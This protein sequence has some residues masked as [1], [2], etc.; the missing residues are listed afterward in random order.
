MVVAVLVI[1]PYGWGPVYNFP[2]PAPFTGAQIWNPYASL[3]GTWQRANLH[4]HGQAWGGLTNGEQPDA[5]VATRYRDLGYTVAG[6]SNYMSIAAEHGIDTIPLYEHGFNLGKNHQLAIGAHRVDWFDF[7]LWQTRSN[8]QYVINRVRARADLVGLNH[9][10]SRNAYD[11][12]AMRSLTGYDLVEVANGPFIVEDV[13]DAALSSGRAVWAMANDDTHDL[14]DVRRLGV[15][16]NQIDAP[17]NATKEVVAALHN[18]RFYAVLRTGSL[19]GSGITTLRSLA[20]SDATMTVSLSGV[21]STISFIGTGGAVRRVVPD[22]LTAEYTLAPGDPYVRTVVTTPQTTLYLNP[23][24]RWDGAQPAD[25]SRYGQRRPDLVAACG[26]GGPRRARGC[27]LAP[28][29]LTVR[30]NPDH[31][32]LLRH[33]TERVALTRIAGLHPA[34]EPLHALRRRAVR[35]PLR[36]HPASRHLLQVDRRR[37]TAAA[38]SASS[39]SPGSSSTLPL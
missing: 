20:V 34:L 2:P 36:L 27:T 24:I 4:A 6:V 21:P 32:S 11:L 33:L 8:Q 37:S 16:W 5:D 13:W 19:E 1:L 10:S 22:T 26:G 12:R 30:P 17:S 38:R 7:P 15:G 23:V 35:E 18:G 3:T 9:P 25:A 39:A 14:N 29:T 31:L 28:H